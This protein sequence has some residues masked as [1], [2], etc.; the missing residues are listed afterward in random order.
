VGLADV[1]RSCTVV[2]ATA[3]RPAS[4]RRLLES[5]AAD[6][7]PLPREVLVVD[8]APDDATRVVARDGGACWLPEL[9]PG[10]SHALNTGV[11]AASGDVV[12]FV[13]DDV[14]VRPGWTAALV[15]AVG[16]PGVGA[17]G[18]RV[19]PRWES[20]PPGWVH[21]PHAVHLTLV[22][23]GPDTR[24]LDPPAFPYGASLAVPAAV[25]RALDPPFDPRLGPRPGLKLGHEEVR[26]AER[27]R[28]LGLV[29]VHAPEAVVEHCIEPGRIDRAR[30]RRLVFQSGFGAA[31]RE[32]LGGAPQRPVLRRLAEVAV[33][34][35]RA[36]RLAAPRGAVDAEHVD[37]ETGAW[38]MLGARLERLVGGRFPA[39]SDWL[40]MHLAGRGPA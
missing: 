31:R 24:Q 13:D 10:K 11:A 9:R 27:I 17:A 25:L 39:A 26:L 40:A 19:L 23:H 36:A 20:P 28:E 29:V 35:V 37:R 33:S 34:S 6:A 2:V 32:R 7:A 5:L 14:V 3:G 38:S 21:G 8:N 12:L 18:A 4:L 16:R 1:V 30:L 15:A 22:D